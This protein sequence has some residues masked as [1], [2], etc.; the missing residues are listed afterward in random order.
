M[1]QLNKAFTHLCLTGMTLGAATA[2]LTACSDSETYADLVSSEKSSIKS[3]VN[4]QNIVAEKVDEDWVDN[5]TT[6]AVT[7]GEDPRTLLELNKW[8]T[9]TEG[10]FKRLY[11][12]IKS[13]GN[14]N[15][16]KLS[17]KR[18]AA[19]SNALVRYDSCYNLGTFVDFETDKG[20]NLDPNSYEIIYSWNTAYYVS[21]YYA[22]YYGTGSSYECTSAGLAF[23]LRFLWEG[24]EVALI[25]P[26]SLG[27]ST[28]QSY[29]YTC[30]YGSVKY[31]RPNY[32]PQ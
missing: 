10:D 18:F 19:K 13:W 9:V 7:D 32:L 23:P 12:K 1:K 24:G 20:N 14:V 8:Y 3:F 31:T 25:V 30:Y 4:S 22:T 15:E 17:E 5:M 2:A 6:K 26:F 11:F 27:S 28:D 29:Y 16:D 21:S